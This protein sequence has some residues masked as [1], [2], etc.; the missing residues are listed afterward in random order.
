MVATA[1]IGS[2][3]GSAVIGGA[4]QSIQAGKAASSAKRAAASANATQQ[5][6][7]DTSQE[8]LAPYMKTGS[9]A[10]TK[11]EQLEGLNGGGQNGIQ[12]TLEGL[13]GYQFSNYQG[14]KSVQNGATARGLGVS[15]AAL[16]GGADYSTKLANTYYN[17]LLSGIQNT[18]KTGEDAASGLA[19]AATATGAEEG[20]NIIG[21]GAARGAADITQGN[22]ISGIASSVPAA[23]FA[24]KLLGDNST[25]ANGSQSN[26]LIPDSASDVN[27]NDPR[28]SDFLNGNYGASGSNAWG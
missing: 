7:F 14:L 9:G 23:L 1:V 2:V 15:G 11:L 22:A 28:Y 16:K 8:A 6:F 17:N 24:N 19:T 3:V 20:N 5:G 10:A 27:P 12:A 13:P 26:F 18:E 25:S 4:A 21:A